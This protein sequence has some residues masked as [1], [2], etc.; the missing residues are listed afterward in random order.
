MNTSLIINPILSFCET[1]N[2]SLVTFAVVD[3]TNKQKTSSILSL[4]PPLH[5]HHCHLKRIKS[6]NGNLTVLLANTTATLEKYSQTTSVQ[7]LLAKLEGVDTTTLR[8]VTVPSLPPY[9]DEQFQ[10]Y[11]SIWPCTFS[12]PPHPTPSLSLI[13]IDYVKQMF[14]N[15]NTQ[16]NSSSSIACCSD[17][18]CLIAD[19]NKNI[20]AISHDNSTKNP[21]LHAPFSTLREVPQTA[22]S[23]LCTNFDAFVTHEPCLFCGMALLHS[24]FARVFFI[25]KNEVNGAFSVHF[26]HKNR[27]LNHHFNVY[28]ITLP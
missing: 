23:Y 14:S 5:R 9:N 21:I 16:P 10:N 12:P 15:I 28:Q 18:V 26:I 1:Y 11:N 25:K 24:R 22:R 13:D 2:A 17:S 19:N 7:S 20:L 3:I 4:L 8:L 27:A 6:S